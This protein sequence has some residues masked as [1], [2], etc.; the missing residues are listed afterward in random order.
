MPD[1][2]TALPKTSAAERL[3][4]GDQI[5]F[6]PQALRDDLSPVSLDQKL[7]Q[8]LRTGPLPVVPADFAARVV[9]RLPSSSIAAPASPVSSPSTMVYARRA[10]MLCLS[11]LLLAL[12]FTA[13]HLANRSPQALAIEWTISAE[14]A[15]IAVYL[16]R[17]YAPGPISGPY[18]VR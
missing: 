18:R 11:L 6:A 3:T 5:P 16:G 14:V 13:P 12:L 1:D 17:W 15:L 4:D 9:S 10:M 2:L 7:D 8:A